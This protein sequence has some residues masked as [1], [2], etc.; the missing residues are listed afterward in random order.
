M[1]R[2][3]QLPVLAERTVSFA[4]PEDVILKK[5]QYYQEGGSDKHLRDI[6]G[7]LLVQGERVN[8]QDIAEWAARLGVTEV[9]ELVLSR[10]A[11][12]GSRE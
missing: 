4:A 6:A 8:R 10:V 2:V 5:M 1:N 3:R 11:K 7:V 12:S 9:W